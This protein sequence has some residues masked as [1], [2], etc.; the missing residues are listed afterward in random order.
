MPALACCTGGSRGTGKAVRL[1][2]VLTPEE[3]ASVRQSC[4]LDHKMHD[5][6]VQWVERWY[7]DDL[8][9][10]DLAD[11]ALLTQSRDALDDLTNLLSLGTIYDFQN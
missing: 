3:Q 9:P 8:L 6:I 10:E 5:A 2:V 7:P 4:I 11:P 1:R